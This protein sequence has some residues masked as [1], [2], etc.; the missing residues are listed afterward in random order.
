MTTGNDP[1]GI[2]GGTFDPI[3]NG[4]LRSALEILERFQLAQVRFIPCHQPAHRERPTA[5][6][7]QRLAMLE[8]ALAGQPG[9]VVDDQEL[10]RAGPSYMVDSLESLRLQLDSTPLCLLLGV[11]AFNGLPGWHRWRE[12][13]DLAHLVVLHRP[14][15]AL[16]T[17]AALKSLVLGHKL[18]DPRGLRDRPAGGLVFQP[19]TQLDISATE[20]RKLLANQRSPRYLLPES[21]QTYINDHGLYRS[22]HQHCARGH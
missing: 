15:S 9:F 7:A 17:T 8:I 21:V 19:V 16:S 11:D 13:M 1:I 14:G 2:L 6:P 12:L 20:I 22:H 3:H 10:R 5:T 4:H 18:A